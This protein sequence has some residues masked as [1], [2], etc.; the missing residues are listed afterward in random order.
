MIKHIVALAFSN[1]QA[2]IQKN[3]SGKKKKLKKHKKN[4]NLGITSQLK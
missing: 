2:G 3:K 1:F 4:K